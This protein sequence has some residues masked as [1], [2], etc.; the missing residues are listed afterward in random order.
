[1]DNINTTDTHA[2]DDELMSCGHHEHNDSSFGCRICARQGIEDGFCEFCKQKTTTYP[3]RSCDSQDEYELCS[4][5]CA[6]ERGHGYVE[7]E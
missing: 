4:A 1:M 3:T 5:C 2:C 7:G 6:R